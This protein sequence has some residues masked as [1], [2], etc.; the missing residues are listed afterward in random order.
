L[1]ADRKEG[2]IAER[3]ALATHDARETKLRRT[4]AA[5]NAEA[6]MDFDDSESE[7]FEIEPEYIVLQKELAEERKSLRDEH[8][9]RALKVRVGRGLRSE[10]CSSR[11][12]IGD[13]VPPQ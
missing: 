7:D 13:Y 6:S 9:S 8:E 2:L 3:T 11:L 12:S 10:C 1:I 5:R 4:I